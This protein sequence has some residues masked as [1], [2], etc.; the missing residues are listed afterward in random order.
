[1]AGEAGT[2]PPTV[3]AMASEP[4]RILLVDDE[5]SVR[6]SL[7]RVLADRGYDVETAASGQEAIA[8]LGRLEYDL[9]LTD[10]AMKNGDGIEVLT[11]VR[12]MH[13]D[14]VAIML[15]GFASLDTAIEA[16]RLGA[17]DYLTKPADIED[18]VLTLERG[19]AKRRLA[20]ALRRRN[21]ELDAL[22]RLAHL[23][24]GRLLEVSRDLDGVLVG[25]AE[26]ATRIFA[27]RG[28]TLFVVSEGGDHRAGWPTDEARR[29]AED[30]FVL[31]RARAAQVSATLAVERGPFGTLVAVPVTI[32]DQR[33]GAMVILD[34][35]GGAWDAERLDTL[36]VIARR[37][38]RSLDNARLYR[39]LAEQKDTLQRVLDAAGD[40]IIG[41]DAGHRV[42]LLSRA[43]ARLLGH[44]PVDVIG[45]PIDRL[46]ADEVDTT[47]FAG[48]VRA[49][50]ASPGGLA[51]G[52]VTFRRG[53]G[54]RLHCDLVCTGRPIADGGIHLVLAV[55]DATARRDE[56]DRRGRAFNHLTHELRT[57]L[58][59]I[60][61]YAD[62][63][64]SGHV[65]VG[66]RTQGRSDPV[67]V[68]RH[69]GLLL[70]TLIDNMLAVARIEQGALDFRF[71][72]VRLDELVRE[73]GECLEPLALRRGLVFRIELSGPSAVVTCD[74]TLMRLVV[75]NLLSNAFRYTEPGGRV[76]LRLGEEGELAM[77]EVSDTGI[78]I[79]ADAQA[80]VFDPHF[81]VDGS[82][83]GSGLGL[84]IVRAI[85]QAH[86][87]E[88]ELSS[89]EG[90][91]TTI[92]V[93]LPR[94][95]PAAPIAVLGRKGVS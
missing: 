50:A 48:L 25:I 79:P 76:W 60:L 2:R 41:L 6:L 7:G 52:E 4:A 36:E 13:P 64:A 56:L 57:P 69:N 70:Q 37:L 16:I 30:A 90:D 9:V 20:I 83:G 44:S 53:D 73:S 3:T 46:L 61:S 67:E 8:R 66:E 68:I 38:A 14:T 10:L 81:Q 59:S 19:L 18:M 58:T 11:A 93:R 15:T 26:I 88:V 27:A 91:G 87:G 94:V 86:G 92:R 23:G 43:A 72:E 39:R 65:R 34:P 42:V 40:G 31:E 35:A 84:A 95:P 29:L 85:V 49:A 74:R 82:R 28:A 62:L 1:V 17:Y 5:E 75:N 33:F 78:G 47:A 24:V 51:E 21:E 54:A 89:R 12:R 71:Q 63:L 32:H 77:I 80:R 45:A 22:H 55:R